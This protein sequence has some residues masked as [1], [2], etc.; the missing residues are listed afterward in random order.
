M[1]P[2][3]HYVLDTWLQRDLLD[4]LLWR[5]GACLDASSLCAGATAQAS[6]VS[7]CAGGTEPTRRS[8]SWALAAQGQHTQVELMRWRHGPRR[9]RMQVESVPAP[10]WRPRIQVEFMRW[11]HGASASTTHVCACAM[12]LTKPSRFYALPPL[13]RILLQFVRWRH[14]VRA[15]RCR[16]V[17][18]GDW[19]LPDPYGGA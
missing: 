1:N 18:K 15:P 4:I 8:P 12:A 11:R 14:G 16:G 19:T 10:L 6:N 3:P 5:H 13:Y 2:S 7:F 9:H 17:S